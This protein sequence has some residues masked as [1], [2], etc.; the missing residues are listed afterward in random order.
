MSRL[1]PDAPRLL[2]LAPRL[3]GAGGISH[4]THSAAEGFA[5]LG[6]EVVRMGLVGPAEDFVENGVRNL[7][8]GIET[9]S[10]RGLLR[11]LAEHPQDV[12]LSGHVFAFEPAFPFFPK[13]TL[14]I[15]Q[16]H[17][18]ARGVRRGL[19]AVSDSLD[20]IVTVGRHMER[21]FAP[22]LATRGWPGLLGTVHNGADF[23][24]SPPR[25]LREGPLRLLF[26]GRTDPFKGIYDCVKLL[27]RLKKLGV[28]AHLTIVGVGLE[29][30]RIRAQFARLGLAESVEWTG[31]LPQAECFA[32]AGQ[33]DVLFMPS[34]R[35]AFGMVTVEAMAMG[36]VPLA[37][38]NASG[39]AEIVEDG[40]NGILV[41]FMDVRTAAQALAG[42]SADREQLLRLSRAAELRARNDF[43]AAVMTENLAAYIANTAENAARHPAKR[44]EGE[45]P[46][47]PFSPTAPHGYSK[48]P[49][50]LRAW[51]RRTV[52]DSPFLCRRVIYR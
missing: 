26:M 31:W 36:C 22:E 20:G 43:S 49:P 8:L 16:V 12:V 44:R 40:K 11:W 14:H 4:V 3:S 32:R 29:D 5:K 25:S 18:A 52:Y 50:G 45:P 27:A 2:I 1:L 51:I 38:D 24:P 37:Y 42:L 21:Q 10:A 34:R 17:D 6:W 23:P 28:P 15:A 33:A 39:S 30:E 41:P 7:A 13:S 35:D 48:L 19:V 9:D 47:Q 46:S